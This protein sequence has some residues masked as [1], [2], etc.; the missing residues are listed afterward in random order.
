LNTPVQEI[1][2][3]GGVALELGLRVERLRGRVHLIAEQVQVDGVRRRLAPLHGTIGRLHHLGIDRFPHRLDL[4]LG[5]DS[6]LCEPLWKGDQGVA[7]GLRFALLFRFVEPLIIGHR[8]AVRTDH[9]CMHQRGAAASPAV[10]LR[11]LHGLIAGQRVGPVHLL[12][13]EIREA[14][15]QPGDAAAGRIHLDGNRDR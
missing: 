14:L 6:Q 11:L 4:V 2:H 12:D 13:Q 5:G 3:R 7:M 8:V 9:V 1:D 15:D 10:L